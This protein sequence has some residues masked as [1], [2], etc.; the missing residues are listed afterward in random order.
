MP[1][2]LIHQGATVQ[3]P[4]GGRAVV[5]PSVRVKVSGMPVAMASVYAVGGCAAPSPPGT[6]VSG[7]WMTFSLRV[8]ADGQPVVLTDSQSLSVASGT[9]LLIVQSQVRAQGT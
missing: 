3:C 5:V 8:K 9:P 1:G 2:F 4:H 7:K 6:C